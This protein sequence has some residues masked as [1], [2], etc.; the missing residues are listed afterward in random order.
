MPA[1][2]SRP[3]PPCWRLPTQRFRAQNG[4]IQR[5]SLRMPVGS[6]SRLLNQQQQPKDLSMYDRRT[7]GRV[8][9]PFQQRTCVAE[10]GDDTMT[11]IDSQLFHDVSVGGC[12]FWSMRPM[13]SQQLWI[14]LGFDQ[15]RLTRL[16]EVCHQTAVQCLAHPV[17]LVGC[18]FL[19]P[20]SQQ[21]TSVPSTLNWPH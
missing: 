7:S 4:I 17:Y 13:H 15:D 6:A 1:D 20:I 14:E 3:C 2:R 21:A 5:R 12:S 9:Y 18:R 19:Q 11:G 16:A 10:F 8:S